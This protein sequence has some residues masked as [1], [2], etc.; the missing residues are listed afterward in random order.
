MNH[1]TIHIEQ[2]LKL[3]GEVTLDGAKNSALVIIASLVMTNGKSRLTNVPDNADVHHMVALLEQL[4]AQAQFDAALGVLDVDTST[5]S[6]YTVSLDIMKKMRAS[7][8]VMGPLLARFGRAHIALPGGCTLGARPIDYHLRA[9]SRMGAEIEVVG[10]YLHARA[11]HLKPQRFILEYPSV[12][13]TENI[14]MAAA[15]CEGR[16]FIVNAA[17]EPEVYD[18][19][20]VLTKMGAQIAVH[21]PAVIEIEGVQALSPVEHA[22]MP[23][24]LEAGTLLLAAAATRGSIVIPDAPAYALDVFLDKLSE[25]GHSIAVGTDGVGVALVATDSPRAV[26]FKTMPYP[27]FPTDLQAPMTTVLALASGTSVVHETV[28][29]NRLVHVRELEKMG[30]QITIHGTT[31]TITGVEELYGTS[32]IAPDIRGS[33]A[34]I[35]AGLAARGTTT[36]TGIHHVRRG[37][38]HIDA[39]LRALGGRITVMPAAPIVEPR[40]FGMER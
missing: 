40:E 11:P 10:D 14:M 21:A 1:E 9:F 18:L 8:L 32:V 26:S 19:I 22:I 36:M 34:L 5:L 7:I 4:G 15:L 29:E 25:M 16:T 23:D 17:L 12:G 33:A 39:K 27:G 30:A 35:I 37:Y 24:R 28:Y 13:A 20:T 3:S 6:G 2:S 38:D 31:A